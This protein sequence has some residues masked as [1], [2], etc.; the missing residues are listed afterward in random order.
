MFVR[1]ER[2]AVT[3]KWR[4]IVGALV[5]VA[6]GLV[7]IGLASTEAAPIA[8]VG[9]SASGVTVSL[10]QRQADGSFRDVSDTYVP[11]W[12]PTLSAESRTV[13]VVVNG[14]GS[15]TL[16]D[17]AP[18]FTAGSNVYLANR[19]TS[20]YPGNCTN[21]GTDTGPDFTLGA[22]TT[23]TIGG[24]AA[25]AY[26]LT[27]QDCGGMAVLQV[28]ND[29]FIVPRDA[30][31][32]GIPDVLE[33]F[34]V[35]VTPDGDNDND[36]IS[37]FD[38]LRGFIVGGQHI[39]T[40]PTVKDVFVHLVKPQCGSTSLLFG[41]PVTYPVAG[42]GSLTDYVTPLIAIPS[43]IPVGIANTQIH[44]LGSSLTATATVQTTEWVDH[45]V[46]FAIVGGKETWTY[47]STANTSPCGS[48]IVVPDASGSAA[49]IPAADRVINGN[50]VFGI[51]QKGLRATECLDA[52]TTSPWGT[53]RWGSPNNQDEAIVYTQRIVNYVNSI[54]KS[55]DNINYATYTNG[56]WETPHFVGAGSV[57]RDFIISKTI[58]YIFAMEI[59]HT[60]HL[61]SSLFTS[62]FPHDPTGTGSLLDAQMRV[63]T[64]GSP[65]GPKF[66]IPSAFTATEIGGLQLSP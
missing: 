64:S 47:C 5:V 44:Y 42:A 54:G 2:E 19:T 45:F 30:N 40:N 12:T 53:G 1:G 49:A 43:T 33:A 31:L 27:G 20:H 39:R 41:G 22:A 52:S 3:M 56:A 38:E 10:Y 14:A 32:N 13:Y 57:G 59:G 34:G 11:T 35:A 15:P 55:G 46:S 61:T 8:P 29:T 51:R 25:T 36:G 21:V 58:Q 7:G 48:S 37:N 28:G 63:S 26:P 16:V 18:V 66:Y 62:T 24:V 9:V 17:T 50:R 4:M 6:W 60:L 23:I 65:T